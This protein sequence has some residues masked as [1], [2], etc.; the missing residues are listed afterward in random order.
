MWNYCDIKEIKI[1]RQY[2]ERSSNRHQESNSLIQSTQHEREYKHDGF[3]WHVGEISPQE[4]LT[5]NVASLNSIFLNF[6]VGFYRK[7]RRKDWTDN[8]NRSRRKTKAGRSP[9]HHVCKYLSI[10]LWQE[11]A[12]R[13]KFNS[14]RRRQ[15]VILAIWR[16][17][18]SN[19]KSFF[20]WQW[21][22]CTV[23][24]TASNIQHDAM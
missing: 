18:L 14:Q 21:H 19:I 13:F 12:S 15:K 5:I 2:L 7:L 3:R 17:I 16:S 6:E 4:S 20:L 24:P 8:S 1:E 9:K 23:W 10:D 11:Y 22:H